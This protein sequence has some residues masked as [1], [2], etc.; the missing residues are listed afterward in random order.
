M[1]RLVRYH[2]VTLNSTVFQFTYITQNL[3]PNVVVE[4]LTLL[5]RIRK[6]PGS[7]LDSG[8]FF[9]LIPQ[10]L[11]TNVGIVATTTSYQTLSHSLSIT[12][13]HIIDATHYSY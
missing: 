2:P 3:S 11:Q 6:L 5:L 10:S 4:W 8:E 12:Y 13:H 7:N 9:R 1:I